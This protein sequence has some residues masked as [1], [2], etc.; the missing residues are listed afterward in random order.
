[1]W[2][3]LRY[4]LDLRDRKEGER[5]IREALD[6]WKQIRRESPDDPHALAG[7]ADA[8]LWLGVL[9][10]ETG[11]LG[12]AEAEFRGVL[13]IPAKSPDAHPHLHTKAYL[14][15][16]LIETGRAAE[17]ELLIGEVIVIRMRKLEDFPNEYEHRRRLVHEY[18]IL[19]RIAG[20]AGRP[21]RRNAPP[22]EPGVLQ[23]VVERFSDG[24][25]S[26]SQSGVGSLLPGRAASG[27]G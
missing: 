20:R 1:M 18:G 26:H 7:F 3:G 12:E 11:R 22:R 16:L 24:S 8:R 4:S 17:A 19:A 15:Q 13:A 21:P 9:F 25:P 23:K 14:A 2:V 27:H 6:A 10:L 5:Y